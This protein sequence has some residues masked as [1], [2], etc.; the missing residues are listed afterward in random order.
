M[1]S[2]LAVGIAMNARSA[3]L[4][5]S[6]RRT[7]SSLLPAVNTSEKHSGSVRSALVKKRSV[8]ICVNARSVI[9]SGKKCV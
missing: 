7:G 2:F 9:L 4:K 6:P 8:C 1:V 3:L 5:F